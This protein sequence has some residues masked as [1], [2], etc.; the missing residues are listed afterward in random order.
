MP[1][2]VPLDEADAATVAGTIQGLAAPTRLRLLLRLWA[3]P[4]SV[5]ELAGAIGLTQS[6][7]SHQLRLLR[8]LNLVVTR[9]DGHQIIYSL[10]DAHVAVLLREAIYHL[11]HVRG[12]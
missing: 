6:A 9:R 3:S 1:E 5:S 4:A 2:P 10:H 8:H 7:V 12:T 11:E